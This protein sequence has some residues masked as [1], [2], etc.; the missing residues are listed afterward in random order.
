MTEGGARFG[1]RNFLGVRGM[2]EA[3]CGRGVEDIL[4]GVLA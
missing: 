4:A 3:A 2:V 1:L